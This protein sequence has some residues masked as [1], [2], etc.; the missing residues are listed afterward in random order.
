VAD[1]THVTGID[2]ALKR[3]EAVKTAVARRIVR[4]AVFKASKPILDTAKALVALRRNP[5]R[6][7]EAKKLLRKALGRKA[8]TFRNS[9]TTVVIIGPRTGRRE[10]IGV[11]VKNMT[12][13]KRDGTITQKGD[14]IEE[15]PSKIAHLV[16]RG[17]YRLA[18]EPFMR[19]AYD[20]NKSAA[21]ATME[22]EILAGVEK[23]ASGG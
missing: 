16:E 5:P 6:N 8:K 11:R 14:P 10:Q 17:G 1:T 13:A 22:T 18:A 19:P 3:L 20:Q 15:D 23:V 12:H 21:A 2:G 7:I 4:N 9:G